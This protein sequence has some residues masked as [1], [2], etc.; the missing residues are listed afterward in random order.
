MTTPQNET[1]FSVQSVTIPRVDFS[2]HQV[3]GGDQYKQAFRVECEILTESV[4]RVVFGLLLASEDQVPD[5]KACVSVLVE[6]EGRILVTPGL[7][8]DFNSLT[9]I[10][11]LGNILAILY[12]FIRERVYSCVYQNGMAIMLPPLNTIELLKANAANSA[13][14]L[15]D[16]RKQKTS[17]NAANS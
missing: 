7:A 8:K 9:E 12:P 5:G 14:K 11:L 2:F 1:M 3:P 13:F 17:S 15:V 16:R 6:A 10:P 4:L